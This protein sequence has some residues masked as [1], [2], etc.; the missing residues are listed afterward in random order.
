MKILADFEI[1]KNLK[2]INQKYAQ[3]KKIKKISDKELIYQFKNEISVP[4]WVISEKK[5]NSLN[6]FF[7]NL[8]KISRKFI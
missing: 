3:N 7:N 8:A 1:L 6:K 5:N 2:T 4:S